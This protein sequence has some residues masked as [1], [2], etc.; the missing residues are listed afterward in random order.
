MN[1]KTLKKMKEKKTVKSWSDEPNS[2]LK[3]E[4]YHLGKSNKMTPYKTNRQKNNSSYLTD[5][6]IAVNQNQSNT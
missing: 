5:T 4:L 2:S 6:M 3:K 1:I